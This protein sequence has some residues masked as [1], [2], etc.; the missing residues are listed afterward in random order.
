VR[1]IPTTVL[2][3]ALALAGC[4]SQNRY[5]S[6]T[7]D[8]GDVKTVAILPFESVT[9][10]KLAADRIQKIFFTELLA[11]GAFQV[12]EPGQVGFVMRRERIGG[13]ALTN[14]DLKKLGQ[15]LRAEAF[16][17]GAVIEYDDGRGGPVPTPRVKLLLRL[18]E[19]ATGETLWSV[20]PSRVGATVSARL[21]GIGGA[22]ASVI[23]EELIRR[24]LAQLTR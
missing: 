4:S 18:V 21:F 8:L 24:E 3:V 23:A 22:P 17:M 10:D 5:V 16:F 1:R 7:A 20:G 13:E 2:V 14:E 11:T 9:S 6:P 19:A 15:A 12:V